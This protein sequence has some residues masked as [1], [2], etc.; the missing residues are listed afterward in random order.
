MQFLNTWGAI[1]WIAITLSFCI[2][3]SYTI[4]YHLLCATILIVFI[5][6]SAVSMDPQSIGA[7]LLTIAGLLLYWLGLTIVRIM[8][9]RSVSL[10]MLSGYA[11]GTSSSASEGIVSRLQDAKKFGLFVLQ[12]DRYKLTSFG[13]LIGLIVAVSYSIFR[14][15]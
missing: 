9:L 15:K 6:I 5:K 11:E 14:V 2:A 13:R 7:W 8:L 12:G 10:R 3:R 1:A 4:L